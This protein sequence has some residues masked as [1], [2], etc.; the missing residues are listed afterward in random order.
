MIDVGKL[1]RGLLIITI[2]QTQSH[3]IWECTYH[4]VFCPKYRKKNLY[5]AARKAMG[6]ILRELAKQKGI[7]IHE[8]NAHINHIHLVLS[9]PPKFSVAHTVGFLKGKSAILAHKRLSGNPRTIAQKSFWSRGY[10]VRTTGIDLEVVKQYVRDQWKRD[11]YEEGT[12]LDF[13]W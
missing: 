3:V 9:I 7:E 12:Q 5:G 6:E 8:G 11:Q 10:F 2:M 4:I 13:G 1:R